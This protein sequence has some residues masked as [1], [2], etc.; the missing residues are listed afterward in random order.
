M[1]NRRQRELTEN[2]GI[3]AIGVLCLLVIILALAFY[4]GVF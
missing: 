4:M 2:R 1:V 3:I